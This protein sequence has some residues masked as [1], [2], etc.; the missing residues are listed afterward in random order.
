MQLE[1][2]R[3]DA[4]ERCEGGMKITQFVLSSCEKR[5]HD[6]RGEKKRGRGEGQTEEGENGLRPVNRVQRIMVRHRREND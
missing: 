1:R 2:A 6:E 3:G 4:G 5:M